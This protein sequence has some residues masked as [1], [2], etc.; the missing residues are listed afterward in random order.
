[1]CRGLLEILCQGTDVAEALNV[2]DRQVLCSEM[3]GLI[4]GQGFVVVSVS[5]ATARRVVVVYAGWG[6]GRS[7]G[8]PPT[9]PTRPVRGREQCVRKR[10]NSGR[11]DLKELA[12]VS[13][14]ARYSASVEARVTL[15]RPSSAWSLGVG[16]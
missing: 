3:A 8:R 12:I 10:R 13:S 14:A 9:Y 4:D 7:R 2:A 5:A 16:A 11:L 15:S 1:V 6:I